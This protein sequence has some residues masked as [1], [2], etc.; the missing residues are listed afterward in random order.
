MFVPQSRVGIFRNERTRSTPLDPKLMFWCVSY[1]L[2][3]FS[4][5][6]L[7]YKTRCKMGWSG[8]K[9]VPRSRIRIF[10]NERT[11]STPLDSKLTFGCVSHYSG[12]FG[13]LWLPYKT[14]CK[15]GR[16]GAK[17]RAMKSCRNFS[18]QTTRS[19]PLDSKLMFWCVSFYLGAFGIVWLPYKTW[20]KTGR[21][22]AKVR[23]MKSCRNFSQQTTRSTP[24]DPNL[25][26]RCVSHY[27]GAFWTFCCVTTLS[28]KRAKLV[29]KFVPRSR[30]GIFHNERTRSTPLDSK[31]M[32]WCV[33]YY[34]SAF[35][36][37]W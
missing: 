7:P 1:Y 26:F 34:L 9:F 35:G 27:L 36:T 15:T 23:A 3:A 16:S 6:W 5:V 12:A 14:Q 18:Q 32:F 10:R 17:V 19:T 33:S 30:V 24:L 29:Q 2:G 13:T 28:S 11:R 22:G 37:V 8:S 25:M 4:T 20:C 21:S 31:L